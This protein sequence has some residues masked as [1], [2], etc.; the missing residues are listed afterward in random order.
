MM[1]PAAANVLVCRVID[2][3]MAYELA[4]QPLTIASSAGEFDAEKSLVNYPFTR[5][6]G[7]D[8]GSRAW[9]EHCA[10]SALG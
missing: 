6:E 5:V 7:G 3:A 10:T 2:G 4:A 9:F 1:E 8:G